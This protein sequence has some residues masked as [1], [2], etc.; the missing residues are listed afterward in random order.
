MRFISIVAV[1]IGLICLL[2]LASPS[3]GGDAKYGFSGIAIFF[4]SLAFLNEKNGNLIDSPYLS[5]AFSVVFLFYSL[6]GLISGEYAYKSYKFVKSTDP[7]G[8][9]IWFLICFTLGVFSLVT[10]LRKFHNSKKES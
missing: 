4:F 3:H 2:I 6:T 9:W 8:F 1:F 7:Q 10:G 5:F